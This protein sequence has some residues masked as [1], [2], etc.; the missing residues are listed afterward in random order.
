M[1]CEGERKGSLAAGS[2]TENDDQE[3]VVRW[4]QRKLQWIACQKRTNVM[5]SNVAAM[6]NRPVVSIA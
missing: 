2:G 5:P 4:R 1:L 3:R 6:I